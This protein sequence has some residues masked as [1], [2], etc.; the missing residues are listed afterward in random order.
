MIPVTPSIPDDPA[1]SRLIASY[2]SKLDRRLDQPVGQTDVALDGR[3]AN[4]RSQETN[5]GDLIADAMRERLKT[6]VAL[7]NGGGIR[8]NRLF[9][10][11]PITRGDLHALLPFQNVIG[12]VQVS[13]V[14]LKD[15]MEHAVG[16]LP[17]PA[18]RFLQVSG[19]RVEVNPRAAQGRRVVALEVGGSPLDPNRRY[20]VA[21][22]HFLMLGGD[23]FSMLRQAK[24]LLAPESGPP[25]I[26][27]LIEKIQLGPVKPRS[28]DRIRLIP[29]GISP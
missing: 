16:A 2:A 17:A 24:Q 22:P 14:T 25:L 18:G 10:P 1:M 13:G 11:G 9:P 3:E 12:V 28:D 23:G 8:G 21:L 20:S 26:Q 7:L 15:V 19:L 5:L 6:D 29:R 27:I 4:V